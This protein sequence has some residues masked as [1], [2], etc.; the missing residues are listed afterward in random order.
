[1][2]ATAA[3]RC[4]SGFPLRQKTLV[5]PKAP[6]TSGIKT[7]E[8]VNVVDGFPSRQKTIINPKAPLAA[9]M[10]T[11]EDIQVGARKEREVWPLLLSAA[12]FG[13]LLF[14]QLFN[15][16]K[17]VRAQAVMAEEQLLSEGR[18]AAAPVECAELKSLA[19]KYDKLAKTH[20]RM[21]RTKAARERDELLLRFSVR[22]GSLESYAP[23]GE[24]VVVTS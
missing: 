23:R 2:W 5:N 22:C 14:S 4:A 21:D 17:A 6:A 7:L 20:R 11:I 8:D 13:S 16:D 9:G 3:R 19:E 1:M 18:G 24:S 12:F 15:D 10:R